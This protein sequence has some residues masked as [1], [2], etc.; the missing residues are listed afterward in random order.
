MMKKYHRN[1]LRVDELYNDNK[2]N[3][4]CE[5]NDV[6][7]DRKL[8]IIIVNKEKIFDEKKMCLIFKD[9]NE[10]IPYL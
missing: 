2:Y 1:L 10:R 8:M 5:L 3:L 4:H 7:Y 9:D 6:K